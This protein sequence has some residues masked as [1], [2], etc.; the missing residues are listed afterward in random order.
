MAAGI[1]ILLSV[2]RGLLQAHRSYRPL[3]G[4]LLIEGGIRTAFVLVLVAGGFG[5]AGYALGVF[6]GEV[7]ATVHA[8]WLASRA[9]ADPA[10]RPDHRWR[11][12]SPRPSWPA[13]G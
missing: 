10:D 4:N 12:L 1:W 6:V 11:R 5:V 9:W 13:A 8:R 3:A 2:D 7:V